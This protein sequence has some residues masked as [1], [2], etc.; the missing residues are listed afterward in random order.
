VRESQIPLMLPIYKSSHL[1]DIS[2]DMLNKRN[3]FD[4]VL[5]EHSLACRIFERFFKKLN[6]KAVIINAKQRWT[7]RG[8]IHDACN[9]SFSKGGIMTTIAVGDHCSHHT[10]NIYLMPHLIHDHI[11]E[12]YN[13]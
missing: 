6:I 12:T 10:H 5:N 11:M 2:F 1:I 13:L 7:V 9:F 8:L 4:L 3:V